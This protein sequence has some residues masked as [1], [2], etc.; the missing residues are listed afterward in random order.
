[1]EAVVPEVTRPKLARDELGRLLPGQQSLNPDGRP[2][3]SLSIRTTIKHYLQEHPDK[4]EKLI[5]HYLD[6]S[7]EFLWSMLET[8]PP[9]GAVVMNPDGSAISTGAKEL[10]E[11]TKLL[12]EI[13]SGASVG[14]DGAVAGTVDQEAPAQDQ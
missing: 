11:V 1:M 7:P 5:N 3:G 13:H 14:G 12:N 4:L 9:K 10:L 2:V 8:A 6:K